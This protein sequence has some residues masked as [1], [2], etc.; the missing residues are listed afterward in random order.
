MYMVLRAG[1]QN[2]FLLQTKSLYLSLS[3][4]LP[5]THTR[6]L[7]KKTKE[8]AKEEAAARMYETRAM[9]LSNKLNTTAADRKKL[10]DDVRT[11][12]EHCE[13]LR[14]QLDEL[15]KQLEEETL[16]RVDLENT[17]QSLREELTFKDQVHS[18]ELTETRSRRQV[19]ISE[20]DGRLAEQYEAK[21]QQSLQELRDQ[22]EQRMRANREEIETLF[23]AKLKNM[24]NA[25]QRAARGTATLTEELYAARSRADGLGGRIGELEQQVVGLQARI[26]ELE[27]QLDGERG[28]RLEDEAEMARLR[29]E[30]EQQL[31]E[32]QDLMDIKVS[33][34]LEIAAYDKLLCGEELRLNITPAN[35]TSTSQASQSFSRGGVTSS[36]SGR[37]TPV[38]GRRTPAAASSRAGSHQAVGVVVGGKRKRTVLEESEERNLSD[39][40]VTATSKGDVEIADA[41]ATGKY[42]KL[43]NKSNKVSVVWWDQKWDVHPIFIFIASPPPI[44]R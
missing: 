33:L 41:E 20:I 39:F 18:Q 22:Y 15:R 26:R 31:K 44:R 6:S 10:A 38:S 11:A 1:F 12:A 3:L 43:A 17:V 23:D 9:D 8:H 28:R 4:S 14:R 36:S 25:A 27:A 19:E 29:E 42:V 24:A 16:A 30:M 32:Y 35:G 40:S 37:A 21:L 13:R 2:T 7:D 34:D 5:P